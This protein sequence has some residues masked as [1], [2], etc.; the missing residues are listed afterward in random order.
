MTKPDIP[1]GYLFTRKVLAY[2][3]REEHLLVFQQP[4]FPTAGIQVPAGTIEDEESPLD[5]ITREVIEETGLTDFTVRAKLGI[6]YCDMTEYRKEI[7]ERHVYHIEL[8]APAPREW[9]HYETDGGKS[10]GKFIAFD[11]FWMS[12]KKPIALA[13]GQGEMLPKLLALEPN[14][15]LFV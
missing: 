7:Q 15:P 8:N 3:T 5:A 10:V 9:R 4:D 11:F 1:D 14:D 12:L 2:V 6:Y 13:A